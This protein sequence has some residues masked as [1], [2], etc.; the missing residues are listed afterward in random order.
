MSKVKKREQWWVSE[1]KLDDMEKAIF[2][3]ML[4]RV[5]G[6]KRLD[7]LRE[8]GDLRAVKGGI[9]VELDIGKSKRL[10]MFFGRRY[11][12]YE[13]RSEIFYNRV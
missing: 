8:M 9:R 3:I 13:Y 12:A 11:N 6:V 5:V 10:S 4:G 7:E 1:V 2:R